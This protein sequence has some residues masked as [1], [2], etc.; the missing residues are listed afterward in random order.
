[1]LF[2]LIVDV[3]TTLPP[4]I[5]PFPEVTLT[6]P[7]QNTLQNSS[8][9]AFNSSLHV[10]EVFSQKSTST[11]PSALISLPTAPCLIVTSPPL[12]IL[13]LKAPPWIVML[14]LAFTE[15]PSLTSPRITTSPIKSIFP[16]ATSTS[17]SNLKTLST[18]NLP[19][20]NERFPSQVVTS[21]SPS[22]ESSILSAN[23]TFAGTP[24]T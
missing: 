14:P 13:A 5:L 10:T 17:Q 19:P 16:V 6:V 20:L 7:L 24:F 2:A 8:D 4:T 3:L 22:S 12:S 21:V 11:F 9:F 18:L 23:E 15:K 1:M